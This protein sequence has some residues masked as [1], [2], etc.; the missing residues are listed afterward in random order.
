MQEADLRAVHVVPPHG[1]FDNFESAWE[2]YGLN[3]HWV[4]E[5]GKPV[6]IR[7]TTLKIL[8]AYS[9]PAGWWTPIKERSSAREPMATAASALFTAEVSLSISLIGDERWSAP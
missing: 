7:I 1:R 9:R 3:P 4:S 2:R 5:N 8:P 6:I